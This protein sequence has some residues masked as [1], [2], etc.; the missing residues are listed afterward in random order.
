MCQNTKRINKGK[1]SASCA[2]YRAT[3]TKATPPWFD[4]EEVS[5]VYELSNMLTELS[6]EQYHVDHIIPLH[7][8]EVCGLHTVDNLQVLLAVDNFHKSNNL[9]DM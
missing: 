3:R 5:L 2:K 9:I 8:K 4:K 7:N 6:G 1:C